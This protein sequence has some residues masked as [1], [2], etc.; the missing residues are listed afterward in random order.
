M[1]IV[2][3]DPTRDHEEVY[4][5]QMSTYSIP[6]T[7]TDAKGDETRWCI[8]VHVPTAPDSLE[9]K[10]WGYYFKCTVD[11]KP[12]CRLPSSGCEYFVEDSEGHA[13]W[14]SGPCCEDI[15]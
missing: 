5:A 8:Y 3:C 10:R 6:S 13:I 4:S 2:F 14:D 11:N 15:E 12:D 1:E 9:G 7:C